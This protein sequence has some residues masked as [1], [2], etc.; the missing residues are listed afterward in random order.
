MADHDPES[1]A[2]RP[3]VEEGDTDAP[4]DA[5]VL[6]PVSRRTQRVLNAVLAVAVPATIAW[7][8]VANWDQIVAGPWDVS[9]GYL[10]LAGALLLVAE[11]IAPISWE[12]L[13]LAAGADAPRRQ[14]WFVWFAVEPLKY[15]P[16]PIGPIIGR[17]ALAGRVGLEPFTAAVTIAYDFVIA[18]G[19][20]FVITFPGLI[21]LAFVVNPA[22]RWAVFL[23]AAVMLAMAWA[24]L[25]QGG[26]SRIIADSIGH[27]HTDALGVDI[28]RRALRGPAGI[29]VVMLVVRICANGCILAALT[30]VPTASIPL[31]G[32]VFAI[33]QLVPLARF[34]AREGAIVIGLGALGIADGPAL[35]AGLVSRLMGLAACV[36]WLGISVLIGGA[37]RA[38]DGTGGDGEH[39]LAPD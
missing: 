34:G 31:Y 29:T 30:P 14:V 38:G 35:L 28:P 33:A 7:F 15:L 26:L 1:G 11:G 16:V 19:I 24:T 39:G 17:Y 2:A 23:V 5:P 10:V 4:P 8:V 22:Y 13:M 6:R 20:G 9:P 27:K 12:W 37:R 18:S 25:R 21:W 36:T 32:L 3:V